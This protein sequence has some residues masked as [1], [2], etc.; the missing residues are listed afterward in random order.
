VLTR[1]SGM[2]RMCVRAEPQPEL[3]TKKYAELISGIDKHIHDALKVRL[4]MDSGHSALN[5][6]FRAENR[7]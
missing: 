1:V 5:V 4:R 6:S 7:R 3:P 2:D